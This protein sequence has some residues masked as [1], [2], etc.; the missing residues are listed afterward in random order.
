MNIDITKL[1]RISVVLCVAVLIAASNND[2]AKAASKPN[3]VVILADDLGI[4]CLSTYGGTSHQTPNIDQLATQGMR[5]TNCF[6]NPYCSPSRASL[7]SG[8]YPFKNGL[9]RVIFNEQ[10]HANIY[11]HTDQPSFAR[12]LKKSGYTT[13]IAGKW[14]LCFLHQR[15][16]IND[17][18]FDQYQ[19]WQIFNE[20]KL[21]TRRFHTPHFNRNG[22]LIAEQIKDRYGPEVNV[23]FLIDFIK[24][25]AAKKQPFLAYYTCLLPHFPWVPTPFSKD[26]DYELTN[27]RPKGNP[28]YFPDM[29]RYLDKNVGRMMQALQELD[30]VDNT[31]FIFLA[32]NGTDR[33]L[34]NNWGDGKSI[35][36]GKG[37]MT[38]RG[39][40][41]PLIV[42]WPGH[43]KDG[44]VN[45]DLIDFSDL[46]PTL[47]ELAGAPLPEE[48]LHGRSFLPQLLGK[49]A[50]PRQWVH[51]QDKDDR[52]IRSKE[53][54]LNNKNQ[55]R[56]VVKIWQDP[57]K[58]N[59]NKYPAKEQ[60][61]RKK[62]EAVFDKL[63]KTNE[64]ASQ[65]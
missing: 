17:F 60:A 27:A 22:K 50:K 5:F 45:D 55:L 28:K 36:G 13:A 33:D 18:G 3:I 9:K 64:P 20:D 1:I 19:C 58:A 49:P 32:D 38:D 48:Q 6:S 26:Q 23:E 7:L 43:I 53:Y 56:P 2:S 61:A 11:L 54:I 39:T 62:L 51:V 24:T 40:H 47:C 16:T 12:Q 65:K 14:H 31:V 30:I 29:V 52:Y 21:R 46:F 10:A 59:Q 57:A 8:R 63:N 4:E 35:K 25:N 37:S 34:M 41:V 44:T 42:R 15:N